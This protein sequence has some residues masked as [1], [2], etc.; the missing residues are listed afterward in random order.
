MR[1]SGF[2]RPES[3]GT[4]QEVVA[5]CLELREEGFWSFRGQ[6]KEHW[7]LGLHH[8]PNTSWL[9]DHL[10][11]FTRRCMETISSPYL[12]ETDPWRWLFFAQHYRLKTRLLD[13]TSNPLV[14]IYFAVENILSRGSDTDDYGAVWAVKVAEKHFK[15]PEAVGRPPEKVRSWLMINPPPVTARLSRQSGKFSFH[16]GDNPQPLD[17]MARRNQEEEIVRIVLKGKGRKNPAPE[18]R[19]QLG[20]MNVHHAALFPDSDGIASFLNHEWRDIAGA[21][22][23][24]GARSGR[25]DNPALHRTPTAPSRGRRR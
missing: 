5:R 25:T 20:I 19:K 9:D 7:N 13:W 11:Q 2:F 8:T 24:I 15:T 1:N 12:P 16:P 10:R 22:S 18:I 14:A 23:L 6:R 17:T 21:E 4:L 3:Y